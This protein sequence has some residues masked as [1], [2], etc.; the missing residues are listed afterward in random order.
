MLNSATADEVKWDFIFFN[1]GLHN[2]GDN[3][4]EA[5][6]SYKKELAG[7]TEVLMKTGSKLIFGTTTPDM[8]MF[9]NCQSTVVEMLNVAALE[10]MKENA[11]QTIDLYGRVVEYCGEPPY[12]TCAICQNGPSCAQQNSIHYTE[13][14]YEWLAGPIAVA[15]AEAVGAAASRK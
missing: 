11:I 14:G 1:N 4:T 13:E 7:I 2:L 6:E 15:L 9:I 3:S 12:L 10:V 8:F 5:V